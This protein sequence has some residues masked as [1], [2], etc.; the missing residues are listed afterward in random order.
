M[1]ERNTSPAP[2]SATNCN[3][4]IAED[5]QICMTIAEVEEVLALCVRCERDGAFARE[6]RSA[7]DACRA[8]DE[9]R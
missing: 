4:P 9:D 1:I 2:R 3:S 8:R 7:L 6:L 5:D